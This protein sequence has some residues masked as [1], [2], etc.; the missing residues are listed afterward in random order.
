M[1]LF[2]PVVHVTNSPSKQMSVNKNNFLLQL[3]FRMSKRQRDGWMDLTTGGDSGAGGGGDSSIF[4]P[5]S[6]LVSPQS[7]S[8]GGKKGPFDDG[9][10]DGGTGQRASEGPSSV[11]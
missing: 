8:S 11:I 10:T 2:S 1:L 7:S 9:A 5:G 6:G 4:C 3:P